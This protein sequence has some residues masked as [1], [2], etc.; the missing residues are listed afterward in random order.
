MKKTLKRSFL[1]LMILGGVIMVS[2]FIFK[3]NT[4]SFS[5]EDTVTFQEDDLVLEVFYNRPYKKDRQI[6][7]G[8]VPYGEVWRTGANEATTF[9]TNKDILVDGSLLPAG[10]Y[11]LWTIPMEN[12][13]KVIFNSEMY[14]WGIT[15]DERPSR[16]A[17]FDVLTVE[18]PSVRTE[19]TI[20]QFTI[21]FT[22]AYD[23]IQMNFAWDRTLVRVPIKDVSKIEKIS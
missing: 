11:T 10:K 19:E 5:P 3:T 4:K 23:F 21:D 18:V 2:Y 1:G 8:L 17:E 12:S 7:G 14:P 22:T 15:A 9:F 20:E 13:W 16:V 6:F